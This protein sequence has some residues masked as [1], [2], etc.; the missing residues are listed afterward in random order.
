MGKPIKLSDRKKEW[1]LR[2]RK[3]EARRLDAL[4]ER[5]R[6]LIVCEGEKTEPNYFRAIQRE[7]PEHVVELEICGEGFN[8]LRL[9][10]EAQA[11][12]DKRA[13]GDYSFD[14]VWVVFDRDSFPA[15]HFDNA[16]TKAQSN[17]INAAWSN[18]AFE[19]WYVLHFEC[20][21]TAMPRAEYQNKLST[22]IGR[23]YAK[24]ALDIYQVLASMGSQASAIK[25]AQR[26]HKEATDAHVTPANANPC[27]T[28]YQLIEVLNTFKPEPPTDT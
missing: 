17:G 6:I 22:M 18:E 25:W 27:T 24:N 12:R 26:L 10:E 13:M 9:V 15:D 19:L 16:I 5:E 20:R 7:L 2:N 23:R 8:T 14:Q 11:L 3:S 21:T 1:Y 4:A 28:V